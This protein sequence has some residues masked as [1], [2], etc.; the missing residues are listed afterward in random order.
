MGAVSKWLYVP[1]GYTALLFLLLLGWWRF[2]PPA[3]TD[4]SELVPGAGATT[5]LA[6]HALVQGAVVLA[7]TVVLLWALPPIRLWSAI[8][9]SVA[10]ALADVA[11]GLATVAI[12]GPFETDWESVI[13]TAVVYGLVLLSTVTIIRRGFWMP[14]NKSLE[15]T[16]EG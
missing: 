13:R 8:I 12:A 11:A 6:S 5:W 14:P 7:A 2:G 10:A 4:P 15:R 16:R 1:V 9:I 3:A